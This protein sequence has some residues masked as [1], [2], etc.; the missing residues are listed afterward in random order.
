LLIVEKWHVH[1][2]KYDI[3]LIA[4]VKGLNMKNEE[5]IYY[6]RGTEEL[7]IKNIRAYKLVQ[8]F[9]NYSVEDS[10]RKEKLIKELFGSVGVNPSIEH[11]FHCDLGYNIQVGDNFYAGY[12]CTILDMAE[13]RIG[14]NCMIGPN[15]GLY[16]AG[17]S[18]EPKDRNKS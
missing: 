5:K 12:N 14:Y 4:E 8:E 9:N 10:N 16:T 2:R 13:V 11:N 7:R 17:H 6:Q 15:V 1:L 3:F 18:T